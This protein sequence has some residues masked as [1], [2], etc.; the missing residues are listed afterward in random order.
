MTRSGLRHRKLCNASHPGGPLITI[1]T[2]TYNCAPT[3]EDTIKSVLSQ[4]YENLE[5]IIIDGGSSDGTLDIIRQYEDRISYWISE[6]DNGIYDAMNKGIR[7][8]TGEYV[9]MLNADDYFSSA[10][11]LKWVSE[12]MDSQEVDA[13]HGNL[14]IVDK[15]NVR[16]TLRHY[17]LKHFNPK[18]LRFGIVPAHPTFYCKKELY[19]KVGPYKT[20]YRVAADSEMI[21]RILVKYSARLGYIDRSMVKMRSGGVS[22]NGMLGR[23]RQNFEIVR[24]CRENGLYTN[25]FLLLAKIPVKLMQYFRR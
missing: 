20:N 14:D 13:V 22:N 3:L 9:G 15:N 25:I 11:V 6:N 17:R 24:A 2:V 8:A 23:I 4:S 5:Y 7:A 12:A 16:R 1:V 21:T 10:D 19:D 18:H